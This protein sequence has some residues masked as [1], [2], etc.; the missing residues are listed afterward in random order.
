VKIHLKTNQGVA[1]LTQAEVVK[2]S[3]GDPDNTT[4]DFFNSIAN[5]TFLS[6]TVYAQII[7]PRLAENYATNIFDATKSISE[8]DFPLIPLGRSRS[9]RTQS[10]SYRGGTSRILPNVNCS[11]LGRQPRP[12]YVLLQETLLLLNANTNFAV[13]QARFFAYGET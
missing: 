9:T 13:L 12:K 3:G 7:D 5:G 10:T 11:R 6:W 2:L 4:R 1:N 8:T